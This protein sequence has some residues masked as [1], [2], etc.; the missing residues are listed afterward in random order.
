M[1]FPIPLSAPMAVSQLIDQVD[2]PVLA[3]LGDVEAQIES[4]AAFDDATPGSI[5]FLKE[6]KSRAATVIAE[7]QATVVVSSEPASKNSP[8]CVLHVPEPA[9][10][11]VKALRILCPENVKAEIHP[12]A[13]ISPLAQLDSGV[14]IGPNAVIE[15]HVAIGQGTR[16]GAGTV[17]AR[18]VRLGSECRVGANSVIGDQGLAMAIE[19]DGALLAFPHFGTVIVGDRVEI[20]SNCCIVRGILKNTEIG[21]GVKMANHVNIGHNCRIGDNCWLSG[22]AMVCGSAVLESG[23]MLAA[24]SV[25]YNR[26]TIGAGARVGLGSVV[27]KPVAANTTVFGVPAAVMPF[28]RKF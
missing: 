18:G 3:T 27:V 8:G 28:M 22:H 11:F 26:I 25:I 4:V 19:D 5:V 13:I 24:R 10:W 9:R 6:K 20:G 7:S 17:V 23:V 14:S 1:K 21:D 15:D 16:I 2:E 12:S